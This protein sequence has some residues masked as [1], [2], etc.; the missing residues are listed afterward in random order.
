MPEPE[1]LTATEMD[2]YEQ[3]L[4]EDL[5]GEEQT[6]MRERD[7]E[8]YK[9]WLDTQ[10]MNIPMPSQQKPEINGFHEGDRVRLTQPFKGETLSYEAGRTGTF[11][12]INTAPAQIKVARTVPSYEVLMDGPNPGLI[13][14][15]DG[16]E[17]I[18]GQ[19]QVTY[20]G[21]SVSCSPGQLADGER[22]QLDRDCKIAGVRY[23]AG[24]TGTIKHAPDPADRAEFA[25][26]DLHLIELDKG[27]LIIVPGKVL[28]PRQT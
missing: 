19:F 6:A 25:S 22:I 23:P 8:K 14:V 28:R 16:I 20:S 4:N 1:P 7:P 13:G 5:S 12:I 17:R 15:S 24:I 21:G 11:L 3:L 18:S 26:E 27:E 2:A 10:L 9:A